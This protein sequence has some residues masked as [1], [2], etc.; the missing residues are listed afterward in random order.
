ME[1]D[2]SFP[3]KNTPGYPLDNEEKGKQ[4]EASSH[5][6]QK[7]KRGGALAHGGRPPREGRRRRE[8]GLGCTPFTTAAERKKRGKAIFFKTNMPAQGKRGEKR[9]PNRNFL[10]CGKEKELL[11]LLYP[12]REDAAFLIAGG[13]KRGKAAII[14]AVRGRE[15]RKHLPLIFLDRKG[16]KKRSRPRKRRCCRKGNIKM[17]I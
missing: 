4:N 6:S 8:P 7:K 1:A 12:W 14:H 9:R 2:T 17:S 3:G 10:S 16:R 13:K 15:K 5:S 11:A